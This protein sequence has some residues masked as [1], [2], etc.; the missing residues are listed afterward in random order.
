MN[1]DLTD[2]ET[3][4]LLRELDGLI[5]GDR[6]FMSPRIKT[7]ESHPRQDQ[8]GAGARAAASAAEAIRATTGNSEAEAAR[9]GG[10]LPGR[11]VAP[12]ARF[13]RLI[14]AGCSSVSLLKFA[15]LCSKHT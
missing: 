12:C 4:A 10:E 5:D 11:E 1:L 15:E 14:K 8:A 3:A 13:C 2:E 9:L 6:Y 7:P